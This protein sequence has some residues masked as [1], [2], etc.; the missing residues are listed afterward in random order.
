VRPSRL[1]LENFG[2]YRGRAEVDFSLLGPVFLVCGKTGS[3]KTS[4]FDAM[5]YALYG[6]APGA[7]G[8]LERQ[9][10]SQHARPGEA[11]LVEFEFFLG[12]SNYKAVRN[13]PYRR[14]AKR[15]KAEFVEVE[16]T[17]AFYRREK[18]EMG[19]EWKLLASS[20]TEADAAIEEKMGLSSDEFSKIILLPQGEFQR[21]LEMKS[22]DRVEVL[23]KLFPVALHDAVSSLAKER[24]REALAAVQRVDAELERLGGPEQAKAAELELAELETKLE[25]LHGEREAAIARLSAAELALSRAREAAARAEREKAARE[26]LAA[27][28]AQS[29]IAVAREARI[30]AGKRAQAVAPISR[31]RTSLASELDSVAFNLAARRDQVALFA[32]REPEMEQAKAAATR[33]AEDL[34]II[35]HDL[36]SLAAAQD[37]WTKAA[38]AK[39][40][41]ERARMEAA[42]KAS[43]FEAAIEAE[44]T[45]VAANEAIAVGA[46]EE[47]AIRDAFDADNAAS[48][49]AQ[50]SLREAE[51]IATLAS[52]AEK[53]RLAAERAQAAANEAQARRVAA[54]AV[55][56]AVEAETEAA[57]TED[58][59]LRLALGLVPGSPCPVCGSLEHPAPAHAAI[60]AKASME[61]IAPARAAKDEA[62]ASAA[63]LAALAEAAGANAGEAARELKALD[64]DAPDAGEA[65][66]EARYAQSLC[67]ARAESDRLAEALKVSAQRRRKLEDRRKAAALAAS[68]FEAARKR[69]AD[70]EGAAQKAALEV[71]RLE[72]TLAAAQA[73]AGAE[74]PA[75]LAAAARSRREK[76]VLER[77]A[78]EAALS[79]Y[80]TGRREAEVLEAELAA[81][82]GTLEIKLREAENREKAALMSSGFES[83]E[84]ARTAFVD[85]NELARLEAEASAYTSGLVASRAEVL[86]IAT[87]REASAAPDAI[88][89]DET[90][91]EAAVLAER[92][93]RDATQAALDE[94]QSRS[95]ELSRERDE[96]ERL[97]TERAAL[98]SA[99]SKLGGLSA[100]LNGEMPGR[101]LPFKNYALAAYFRVV[102]E[103]ASAHLARMSD[104]RYALVSD[105]GSG[106]GYVGLDLLVRDSYTG[107]SRPAGTLSGGE[108]FMSSLALALGLADTIRERSGGASLDAIFIDEGFGSLDDETLDR[109]IS[110]LDEARGE[111]TIGIVS[112]VAELRSRIPSRIEVTK[113]RAGSMLKIV[114]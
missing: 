1:V 68:A 50:D 65:I 45:A 81:R 110:V 16:S 43:V 23:E 108:R 100:L 109:A 17:A 38:Q 3:G 14:P 49:E 107:Q 22:S 72:A 9:L 112:H 67:E 35:D 25:V 66:P 11:P 44:A 20:K 89:A 39:A 87:E 57:K 10:W 104:G 4:L 101:R 55:L 47:K 42:E 88:E 62:S 96:R 103:R 77:S 18:T 19:G 76:A 75:P 15:G 82:S 64:P 69:K 90:A 24:S 32:E 5:T 12:G 54:E 53:L 111:R 41:L 95:Q 59:A 78:L 40:A 113:G 26:R 79:S 29:G 27:L 63:T 114:T 102:V 97:G 70:A 106:R 105:E 92:E 91:L 51:K 33:L 99:W 37:A 21:F 71:A 36:G 52:K 73:G 74:D 83:I 58:M 34:A 7:R 84:S 93:A 85:Q 13:P 31:E 6:T 46:D 28:E 80:A 48:R 8:A 2:P 94:A 98:D 60:D 86:A 30:T 56:E 61:S